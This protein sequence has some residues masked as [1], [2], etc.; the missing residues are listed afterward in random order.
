M[1]LLVVSALPVGAGSL[2]AGASSVAAC[3][4]SA[5]VLSV[6]SSRTS[7]PSGSTVL[8]TVDLRNHGA[9]ACSFVTGPTSPNYQVTNA[10]GT[11]VWGSCW[12]AGGPAPC[13]MYLLERVLRP[14]VTYRDVLTWDQR[15]G[16][17]DV[18]VRPGRYRFS[19]TFSGLSLKAA[20]SFTLLAS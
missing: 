12:F 1:A 10:A 4:S 9:S 11:T 6:A 7:Y 13:P 14:G 5:V 2:A 19:V 17:P 3:S 20:T 18:R 8:V 16:H 15:S